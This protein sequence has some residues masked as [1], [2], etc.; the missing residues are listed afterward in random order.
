MNEAGVYFADD[1]RASKNLTLNYGLRWDYF[2]PPMKRSIVGPIFPLSRPVPGRRREWCQ[3]YCR[4]VEILAKLRTPVW[5]CVS[6]TVTYG[7]PGRSGPFYNASG[8][9]AGNMRLARIFL[10]GLTLQTTPGDVNVG[11]R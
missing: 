9:E 5:L 1:Y 3:Q 10:S 8:S 4:C 11:R 2:S 6:G 7:H